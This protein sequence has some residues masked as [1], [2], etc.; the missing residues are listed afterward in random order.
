MKPF[1]YLG[2]RRA[3]LQEQVPHIVWHGVG[4]PIQVIEHKSGV[5]LQ[6]V[7]N[8]KFLTDAPPKSFND[9]MTNSCGIGRVS[10]PGIGTPST[11]L[12]TP[13]NQVDEYSSHSAVLMNR[14]VEKAISSGKSL[15]SDTIFEIEE[16]GDGG[17]IKSHRRTLSIDGLLHTHNN[18]RLYVVDR[19]IY[20]P[21]KVDRRWSL[22]AGID[23]WLARLYKLRS[24]D[25]R[26]YIANAWQ[27]MLDFM[28]VDNEMGAIP[29]KAYDFGCLLSLT[30]QRAIDAGMSTD[31][32]S[33]TDQ[34]Y[35]LSQ[36][37]KLAKRKH[38]EDVH[39]R[40]KKHEN[41][42]RA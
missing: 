19:Q 24:V 4:V 39:A 30:L 8:G 23:R 11:Q 28:L 40:R 20:R 42:G 21:I 31:I 1:I 6:N 34:K 3:L 5:A 9:V 12:G 32:S 14:N 25:Q 16:H 7:R 17:V 37:K 15:P 22:D 27:Q 38:E 18:K 13:S 2:A 10:T 26:R 35:L 29:D 33:S 36:M 41:G